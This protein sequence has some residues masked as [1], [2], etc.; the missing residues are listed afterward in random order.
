M[1]SPLLLK[2][3]VYD[4]GAEFWRRERRG[5]SQIDRERKICM[6][7]AKCIIKLGL[8]VVNA[9]KNKEVGGNECKVKYGRVVMLEVCGRIGGIKKGERMRGEEIKEQSGLSRHCSNWA[10]CP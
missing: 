9:I 6:I 10:V 3:S 2:T 1:R 8:P 7:G 5:G 4:E